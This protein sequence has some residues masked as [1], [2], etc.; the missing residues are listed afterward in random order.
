MLYIYIYIS[1]ALGAKPA[2]VP[3][4]SNRIDFPIELF[5]ALPIALPISLLLE[6]PIEL[7]MELPVGLG[8]ELPIESPIEVGWLVVAY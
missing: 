7:L 8:I 3:F 1:R 4:L 6:L 5:T 2:T